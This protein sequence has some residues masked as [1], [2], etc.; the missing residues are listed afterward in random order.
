VSDDTIRTI[1]EYAG[2]DLPDERLPLLREQLENVLN[3]TRQWEED[4]DMLN[5]RPAHLYRIPW[6][7]PDPLAGPKR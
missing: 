3:F 7:V 2:L 4:L 1:A 6:E 5:T